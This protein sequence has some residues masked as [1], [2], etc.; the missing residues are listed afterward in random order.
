MLS[1][2]MSHH[3]APSSSHEKI[4]VIV[5]QQIPESV[6]DK[7]VGLTNLAS[8]H[9]DCAPERAIFLVLYHHWRLVLSHGASLERSSLKSFQDLFLVAGFIV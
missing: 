8:R 9:N 1:I 6:I 7:I 2:K 3:I 4:F 5:N